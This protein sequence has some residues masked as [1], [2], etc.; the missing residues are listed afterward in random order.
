MA[1]SL[2]SSV[3][4]QLTLLLWVYDRAVNHGVGKQ[5]RGRCSL[6]A[7]GKGKGRRG[8][9]SMCPLHLTTGR[10][11]F[12]LLK[13]PQTPNS[14][15]DESFHAWALRNIQD[16]TCSRVYKNQT[17]RQGPCRA[18]GLIPQAA[19]RETFSESMV[20][21]M[22][23]RTS[24]GGCGRANTTHHQKPGLHPAEHILQGDHILS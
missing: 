7:G 16:P 12:Y 19:P 21:I 5:D 22:D 11:G 9:H 13:F 18:R 24:A 14:A 15:G 2:G 8:C 20:Y 4:N 10:S 6:C 17:E 3:L 1:H 23:P